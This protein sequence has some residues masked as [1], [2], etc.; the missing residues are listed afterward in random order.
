M[1][2]KYFLTGVPGVGKTTIGK[3]LE[4]KGYVVVDVDYEPGLANWYNI[5]NGEK[6]PKNNDADGDWYMRHDWNWDEKV[7]GK[8]LE[9]ENDVFVCGVTSNQNNNLNLFD[10]IFLLQLDSEEIRKRRKKRKKESDKPDDEHDFQWHESFN[11]NLISKGAIKID[12]S[13]SVLEVTR[14]ILDSLDS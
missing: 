6:V 11:K 9:N 8:V 7:L 13:N 14:D 5:K 12:S 4:E 2:K 10:K 3:I 1:N